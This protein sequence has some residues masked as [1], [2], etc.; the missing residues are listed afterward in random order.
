MRVFKRRALSAAVSSVFAASRPTTMCAMLICGPTALAQTATDG[1]QNP[2]PPGEEPGLQTVIVTGTTSSKRSLLTSSADVTSISSTEIDVKAPRSTDDVLELIPGMFVEATAGAVSNNYSVRGLQGGGQ[3]FI[4]FEEDGLPIIYGGGN[5]DEYFSNDITI[6]HIEAVRGGS[7][8]ILTTNGAAATVNFISRRLSFDRQE[9]AFRLSATT[10]NDRR[11][12]FYYSAPIVSNVAFSIGGYLDSTRGARDAG[13]TYQT[14]HIKGAIEKRFEDGGYVRVTG[15]VGDQHDPYYADMPF[16]FG[17]NGKPGD[18]PGLNSLNDNI[19]SPAFGNIGV[20]DSCATGNCTRYFSLAEGIHAETKQIRFDLE[21][22]FEYGL[23]AFGKMHY[24]QY[25]WNFNGIFPGSGT[26]NAGLTS[27]D[28]YLNGS[29]NGGPNAS[30]IASLLIAGRTAYPNAAQFGFQDLTTGQIIAASD[31]GVLGALNGNGLMQQTWLNRQLQTGYDFA[32]NFGGRWEVTRGDFSNSLTVGAMVFELWRTSDQSAVS[33]VINGVSAQSHIY[34]VVALN[35]A[36]QVVGLLTDNGLV[37]YG[38]WGQGMWNDHAESTSVYFNNEMTPIKNLHLD[39]GLRYEV[40]HDDY[41]NGN[42]AAQGTVATGPVGS[43]LFPVANLFD[44]TFAETKTDRSKTASSVGVN[45]VLTPNFSAYARWAFGFQM[46]PGG[47]SPAPNATS[48]MLYEGGLRFQGYGLVSSVTGFHT[49][50]KNSFYQFPDPQN[51]ANLDTFVADMDTDGVELDLDYRPVRS[52]DL[53]AFG[54]YQTPTLSGVSLNGAPAP[55]Y[56]GLTPQHTPRKLFTITPQYFF[57]G[58]RGEFYLR[59]KYIG[60]F[61]AD[62]GDGLSI[63]GYGV[64][65]LGSIVNLTPKLQLNLSV[66]NLTNVIG[67]TEGNPRQGATQ[68]VVNGYFYGRSITGRNAYASL[69]YRF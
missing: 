35:S 61:F 32:S 49:K 66:D 12:D 15:K 5:P 53:N 37:S 6:D 17:A 29:L 27:A 59:Y 1:D 64:F 28:T 21:M 65:T 48:V 62:S 45:Y 9:G 44:G 33:H 23:S 68:A 51:Q 57:P 24:L 46:S 13:F 7:S 43:G 42:T 63:P 10:A 58:E 56:D 60:Q 30:P 19:A 50:F 41:F 40:L 52:F 8:G 47:G 20:P 11:T 38:D 3:S 2:V 16:R 34:N 36:R 67:L 25:K 69:T 26:G 14:Y 55:Q 54:V 4:M 39:F 31:H 18:V 22:P